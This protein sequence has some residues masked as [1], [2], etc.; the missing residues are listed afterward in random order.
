MGTPTQVYTDSD[1]DGFGGAEGEAS[2]GVSEGFSAVGGDCDDTNA[3]AFPG[4]VEVCDNADND[5]NGDVDGNDATDQLTWYFD[6]DGDDYGLDSSTT[7][8]CARP[9]GYTNQGGDCN[10][11]D[12]TINPG[13]REVCD[14]RDEDCSGV[15]DDPY[16][17][18]DA[19]SDG[20]GAASNAVIACSQPDGFVTDHTD[21]D[22][23][24]QDINPGEAEVC[25]DANADEDCDALTDDDDPNVSGTR[26]GY[27]DADADG[28]GNASLSLDPACEL[29]AGYVWAG[30]DCDDA[31]ADVSPDAADACYDDLDQDC[32]A[33]SDNDCDRDGADRAD[34]CDDADPLI[35]P[36]VSEVCG[37]DVDND[38]D[39]VLAGSC[40]FSGDASL[41]DAP[42]RIDGTSTRFANSA[43]TSGDFDGDG[44]RDL[45]GTYTTRYGDLGGA[46][47][48]AS[49][50]AA[51]TDFSAATATVSEEVSYD[52][53]PAN[54]G[55][56]DLD[57]DGFDDLILSGSTARVYLGLV[58]MFYGPFSGSRSMTDADLYVEGTSAYGYMGYSVAAGGDLNGDGYPDA[59]VTAQQSFAEPSTIYLL[60]GGARSDADLVPAV[61]AHAT[62][63]MTAPI[64][65]T[66]GDIDG[67]GRDDLVVR[68]WAEGVWIFYDAST[69][70]SELDADATIVT[71][72]ASGLAIAGDTNDDGYADVIGCE[73]SNDS[74]GHPLGYLFLGP[75]EGK[76]TLSMAVA[77]ITL[78]T[79][80]QDCPVSGAG[81]LNGD[82]NADLMLGNEAEDGYAGTA[83][84]LLSPIS[85]ALDA[86]DADATLHGERTDAYAGTT[87]GSIGDINGD[88]ADDVFVWSAGVK[89]GDD[90]LGTVYLVFGGD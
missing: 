2:C 54:A 28:H 22:D 53:R 15:V 4:G 41:A 12:A 74:A 36:L 57:R 40:A 8:A 45:F 33:W 35:S 86:T 30:D 21:C 79:N 58:G 88:D 17:Y 56:A 50:I 46:A 44:Q 87:L 47:L 20:Y 52:L 90:S 82:G 68:V 11:T 24:R 78:G 48:F 10:D 43:V 77:S 19:D 16:W 69:A 38:C 39:G 23:A 76:N 67:D 25:D 13:E 80:Y 83:Y 14:G 64:A 6:A 84:I 34:D 72:P 73:S 60:L 29:T 9:A 5:C 85:G 37:D 70:T 26:P 3:A 66:G 31:R 75:M 81:D 51:D 49:P 7:T 62:G 42:A 27:R 65:A 71:Y 32:D 59:A 61:Q 1:A 55:A 89:D 63:Y 18:E